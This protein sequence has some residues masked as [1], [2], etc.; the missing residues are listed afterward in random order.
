MSRGLSPAQLTAAAG[1]HRISAPLIEM[2]F[3][4]G[5]LR[6][7]RAPW[8]ITSGANT[9]IAVAVDFRQIRESATSIEGMEFRISGNDL[10]A[11]T[12]ALQ[13]PYR[14]RIVRVFKAYINADTHA[15]IGDP[16]VKFIGRMKSMPTNEDNRTCDIALIAEHYDAELTRPAPTRLNDSDQQRLYPGD[17]GCQYAE[18]MIERQLVWPH[19]DAFRQ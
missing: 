8:N 7:T 18:D 11:L 13:E 12:L 6:I 15:V 2:S 1:A 19:R 14:G 3:D 4:S 10:A 9:Y 17:L 16:V 5:V